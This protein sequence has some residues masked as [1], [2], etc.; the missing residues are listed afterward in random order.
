[1]EKYS[2]N[3]LNYLK[4]I[5]SNQEWSGTSGGVNK[6][7]ES[8][9]SKKLNSSYSVAFNSGTATL[10]AAL[11]ALGVGTGDEVISPAFSVMFNTTSTMHCNAIPIYADVDEDTFNIDPHDLEEKITDKTKAI[12]IVSVYGLTPEMDEIMKIAN[13][14]NIPVIEDNAECYLGYYKGKLAGTFGKFSSFS[15]ENSKH[16]SCG[17]GGILT[18][19]EENLATSARKLGGQGFRVLTAD[20]G[21]TKL[22]PE[23]WQNPNFE[24]H[25]TIGWNYRL[26]EFC[27]AVALAQLEN[28][29]ILVKLRQ[30]SAKLFLEVLEGCSYLTPQFVPDYCINSYWALG[31]KYTGE[32]NIGVSWFDFRKKFIDLGGDGIFGAWKVPYLEPVMKSGNYRSR[33][34]SVYSATNY[35][36][37][38]CPIAEKIQ[39]QMMVFKTNYKDLSVAERMAETLHKTIQSFEK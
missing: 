7:L 11:V 3:E 21:R 23:I 10:H 1:M 8:L 24:R 37:G 22:D 2:G 34:P 4:E 33:L 5:L 30:D 18:T 39:K 15:F 16:I 28:L 20:E 29:E 13:H 25:D 6:D 32:E 26:S 35:E 17:E 14:H 38:L 9:F 27:A 36:E 31:A 12:Q 19:N